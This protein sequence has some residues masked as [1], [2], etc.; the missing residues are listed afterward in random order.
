MMKLRKF[1]QGCDWVKALKNRLTFCKD[2][3]V[4]LQIEMFLCLHG[5]IVF[6]TIPTSS[7]HEKAQSLRQHGYPPKHMT[8]ENGVDVCTIRMINFF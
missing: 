7:E 5:S 6:L 1:S 3:T 4:G 2:D 8:C